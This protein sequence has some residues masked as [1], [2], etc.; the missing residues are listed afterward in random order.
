MMQ[1]NA[2]NLKKVLVRDPVKDPVKDLAKVPV[3]AVN[4]EVSCVDR[5]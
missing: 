4:M 3:K 2:K 1:M 5:L